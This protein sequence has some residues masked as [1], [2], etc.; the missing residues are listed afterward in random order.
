MKGHTCEQQP[1]T[2]VPL[3]GGNQQKDEQGNEKC[4][5][6]GKDADALCAEKRTCAKKDGDSSTER[7]AGRYA[8]NI[9]IS[10]RIRKD[11]LHDDAANSKPHTYGCG[12]NDTR[13]TQIEN[14]VVKWLVTLP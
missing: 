6:G 1:R 4:S 12:Q 3:T 14:R 7:S 10:K 5:C 9:R 8:E 11:R 13:H 2:H